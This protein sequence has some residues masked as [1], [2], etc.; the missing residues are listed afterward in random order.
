VEHP[1]Y[2]KDSQPDPRALP[3][4]AEQC[5]HGRHPASLVQDQKRR[6]TS[7]G[8]TLDH[9]C[10]F[11]LWIGFLCVLFIE[12]WQEQ[13]LAMNFFSDLD[14]EDDV[15]LLAVMLDALIIINIL[16]VPQYKTKQKS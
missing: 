2:S 15:T 9:P 13:V 12:V 8:A 6:E 1:R 3:W 16:F 10:F 5:P 11:F 7:L 14:N 4:Y